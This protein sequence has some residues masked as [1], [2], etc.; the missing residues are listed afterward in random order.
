M[1]DIAAKNS[2]DIKMEKTF[3]RYGDDG[4][5]ID[6]PASDFKIGEK[7]QVRIMVTVK[8]DM[9]YVTITDARPAAFEP[10]DQVPTYNWSDGIF[11]LRETRDSATNIFINGMPKGTFAIK[12]DVFV[13]NKGTF[14]SG[15]ANIQSLYAPQLVAHSNGTIITVE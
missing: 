2:P 15:L 6:V 11:M 12:Y 3:Y 8:R 1:K 4:K 7:I 5:L 13:N 9:N 10:V 14:N